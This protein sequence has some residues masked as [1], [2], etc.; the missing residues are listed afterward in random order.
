MAGV[1]FVECKTD[2]SVT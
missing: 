1:N 2:N